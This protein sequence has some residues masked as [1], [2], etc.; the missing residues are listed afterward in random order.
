MD[1][2]TN[3]YGQVVVV[4]VASHDIAMYYMMSCE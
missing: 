3:E 2:Q 1:G 4:G